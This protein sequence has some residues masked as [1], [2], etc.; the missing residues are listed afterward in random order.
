[1]EYSAGGNGDSG[2]TNEVRAWCVENGDNPQLRLA[3][4]GYEPLAMPSGWTA[5]RWTAPKGYQNAANA[6]NRRREIIWFSP[7]CLAVNHA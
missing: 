4:C 3:F 6:E 1:M 5:L 7:H 2:L